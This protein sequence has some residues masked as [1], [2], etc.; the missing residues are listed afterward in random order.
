M[1]SSNQ[2]DKN[3]PEKLPTGEGVEEQNGMSEVVKDVRPFDDWNDA[4]ERKIN[5]ICG[6]KGDLLKSSSFSCRKCKSN[7]TTLTQK[8][9]RQAD[10]KITVFVLCMV[11]GERWTL[12]C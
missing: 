2:P 5:E 10:E 1:A 7:K 12:E 4:N 11:C 8:Q 9:T 3:T 6:T